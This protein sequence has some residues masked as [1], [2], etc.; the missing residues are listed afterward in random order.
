MKLSILVCFYFIQVLSFQFAPILS[1]DLVGKEFLLSAW[2]VYDDS[3]SKYPLPSKCGTSAFGFFT[4]DLIA[5][6]SNKD[7]QSKIDMKRI[8]SMTIFGAC[9]HGPFCHYLFQFLE[10]SFPGKGIEFILY[11]LAID[12]A[13]SYPIF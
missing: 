10:Q 1:F 9:I 12:Q 6:V 2:K 5:Q 13:S 4:G 8:L 11:K 7:N 3:L